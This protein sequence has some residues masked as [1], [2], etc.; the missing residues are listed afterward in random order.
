MGSGQPFTR[1]ET[2]SAAATPQPAIGRPPVGPVLKAACPSWVLEQLDALKADRTRLARDGDPA[3]PAV[4]RAD[5]A[6]DVLRAGLVTLHAR[7]VSAPGFD[8]G[9]ARLQAMARGEPV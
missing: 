2:A 8:P 3:A 9:L 7:G 5:V 4:S 6:R 1:T